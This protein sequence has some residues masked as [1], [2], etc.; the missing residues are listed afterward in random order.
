[1]QAYCEGKEEWVS[2]HLWQDPA[3]LAS[4]RV[5]TGFGGGVVEVVGSPKLL[6][7][8]IEQAAARKRR[9]E[10]TVLGF[11]VVGSS[12]DGDWSGG[13]GGLRWRG[14]RRGGLG[15]RKEEACGV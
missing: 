7:A 14:R 13:G 9:R 4:I 6:E 2:R 3:L 11:G 10:V 8:G 1:M 15:R 5:V 12:F